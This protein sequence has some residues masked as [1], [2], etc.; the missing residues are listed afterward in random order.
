MLRM[1]FLGE[2]R[3][4]QSLAERQ[5]YEVLT[6]DRPSPRWAIAQRAEVNYVAAGE[7]LERFVAIR[8]CR[9]VSRDGVVGFVRR[10]RT[11]QE[12]VLGELPATGQNIADL[13]GIDTSTVGV[14]LRQLTRVGQVTSQ[15][16]VNGAGAV[17]MRREALRSDS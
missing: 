12:A 14:L 7:A 9:H 2:E 13:L 1:P 4:L 17:F 5:V 15:F 6:L 8:L 16:T 11:I 10:A 3:G